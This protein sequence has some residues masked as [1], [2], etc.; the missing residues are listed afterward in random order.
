MP[1]HPLDIPTFL[2]RKPGDAPRDERAIAALISEVNNRK[3]KEQQIM[4]AKPAEVKPEPKAKKA[5]FVTVPQL[6]EE[7]SKGR[8]ERVR[9]SFIRRTLDKAQWQKR[10]GQRVF[11]PSEV[12]EVKA[13]IEKALA[14]GDVKPP[15]EP[16]PADAKPVTAAPKP[17]PKAVK[18]A[19]KAP[20]KKAPVKAAAAKKSEPKKVQA[21][22]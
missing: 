15:A 4:N 2:I 20:A 11:L 5:E 18:P 3:Q 22:K 12:P 7:M 9:K 10:N 17:A 14:G 1:P 16:K 21:K 8:R 6:A 13:I 19:S